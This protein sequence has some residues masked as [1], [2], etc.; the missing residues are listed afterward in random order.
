VSELDALLQGAGFEARLSHNI[1]QEMWEKWVMLATIGAITTL[2]RG[3]IGEVEAVPGGADLALRMFAECAA[4]AGASGASLRKEFIARARA[5]VTEHGSTRATSMYRDLQ[6][7]R[8]LEVEH[9]LGDL[10]A[11]SRQLSVDAPLLEAALAHLRIYERASSA[12]SA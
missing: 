10:V 5:T 7:G 9:I 12:R 3:K 4:I 8:N 6:H 2:M 1:M 11:R